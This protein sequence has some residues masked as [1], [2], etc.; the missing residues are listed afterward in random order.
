MIKPEQIPRE[1]LNEMLRVLVG[2]GSYEDAFA[3]AINA[4]PGMMQD[5]GFFYEERDNSII[6]P[7]HE[8]DG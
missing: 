6:L 3:A 1:V 8:K 5:H 2:R 4:W 7:L